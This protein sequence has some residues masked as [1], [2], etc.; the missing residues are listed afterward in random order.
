MQ[1]Y[2]TGLMFA[3]AA[4]TAACATGRTVTVG[5]EVA[6]V[7]PLNSNW[8]PAGTSMSARLNQSISTTSS[9]SGDTFNATVVNPVYAQDGTVAVPA[10]TILHGHITGVHN[11]TTPGAQRLIRLAFDDIQMRGRTIPV[12]ASISDVV[13]ERQ[14]TGAATSS[15][16]R[17]AVTGAAAGA[18]LGA[19]ISGADLS[20]ILAAGLLGAAAG[21]VISMG[22]GGTESVLPAGS[23]LSVR[24]NENVRIR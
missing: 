15:T 13:L 10:G 9:R 5:G 21:T 24:T 20:K 6:P 11:T 18:V 7:T 3:S 22:T 23:T 2:H 17:G 1:R 19:V 8:L 16:A 14:P 4:L 12:T